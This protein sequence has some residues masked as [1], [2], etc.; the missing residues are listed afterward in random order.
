MVS[1]IRNWWTVWC[2]NRTLPSSR[3]QITRPL[4]LHTHKSAIDP[5]IHIAGKMN[6]T[7]LSDAPLAHE[8]CRP[9]R[10]ARSR[11][12]SEACIHQIWGSS[13]A[14]LHFDDAASIQQQFR[15]PGLLIGL[16]GSGFP[17]F[18]DIK[19]PSSTDHPHENLPYNIP[20]DR[21]MPYLFLHSFVCFHQTVGQ[22]SE[23]PPNQGVRRCL[24]KVVKLKENP[25][26]HS[27]GF[28]HQLVRN[29]IC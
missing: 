25:Q 27:M 9:T 2:A 6:W 16:K 8:T 23:G 4:Q 3:S 1:E 18:F 15:I 11:L 10:Q 28:V 29:L 7:T 26:E 12:R 21:I 13:R 14:N 22:V 24:A 19:Q 17:Q 5:T 20:L